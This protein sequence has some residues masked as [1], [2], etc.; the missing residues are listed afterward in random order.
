MR[1]PLSRQVKLRQLQDA[2]TDND[3]QKV[4][5]TVALYWLTESIPRG[6]YAF[7]K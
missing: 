7:R 2:H 4:L 3:Q 5:E 6:L 1:T